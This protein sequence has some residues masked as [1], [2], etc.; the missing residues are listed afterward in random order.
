MNNEAK[1]ELACRRARAAN[2]RTT[3]AAS[4]GVQILKRVCNLWNTSKIERTAR[5]KHVKAASAGRLD[6]R[7]PINAKNLLLTSADQPITVEASDGNFRSANLTASK[8]TWL[9]SK[10]TCR[11]CQEGR[12]KAN[13]AT[14]C[15]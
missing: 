14:I 12:R 15:Q 11:A 8:A 13:I 1:R 5:I 9:K 7:K 2:S 4:A 3:A 6:E 10:A